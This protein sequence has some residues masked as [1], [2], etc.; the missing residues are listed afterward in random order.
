[1]LSPIIAQRAFEG[2]NVPYDVK[3]HGSAITYNLV[4]KP[5]L[6]KWAIPGLKGASK[7]YTGT[8]YVKS[9]VRDVFK[10]HIEELGLNTK[11]E[12]LPPGMDP[13]KFNIPENVNE[14]EKVFLERAA[15]KIKSLPP[16]RKHHVIEFAEDITPEQLHNK[17]VDDSKTYNQRVVDA[18]LIEKWMPYNAKDPIILY[19][20]AF[21]GSK[22]V[23]ELLAIAPSL[24][25]KK[26]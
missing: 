14:S 4:P 19:I 23:G 9:M 25:K 10:N 3:I 2:T 21:L 22:G 8:E 6:L 20:G 12:I 17:F 24:I 26:P 18:D 7:I 16:G 5:E 1:M 15:D 11:L 13:E